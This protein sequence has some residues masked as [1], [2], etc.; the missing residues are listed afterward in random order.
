[1]QKSPIL[2]GPKRQMAQMV[3]V[4][5][6]FLGDVLPGAESEPVGRVRIRKLAEGNTIAVVELE[7]PAMIRPVCCANN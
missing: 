6:V 7:R 3:W 4:P 5:V 1:M 2:Q